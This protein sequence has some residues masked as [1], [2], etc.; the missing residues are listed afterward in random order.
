MEFKELNFDKAFKTICNGKSIKQKGDAGGIPITRIETIAN[1]TIDESKFGYADI[2]DITKY[3]NHI[4][5]EGDILLSHINSL[6][7]IGKTALFNKLDYPV[8]HGM[9]L[10]RLQVADGILDPRYAFYYLQTDS[11]KNEILKFVKKSVNQVSVPV[12]S[13]KR[14]KI[15]FPKSLDNQKRIVQVLSNCE[16][17]IQKRK[18][19]ISLLDELLK[20]TF[21]EM[22]GDP[23]RNEKKWDYKSIKEHIGKV[24]TGNTPPRKDID[25]YGDFIEW[26]K[27][28]NIKRKNK[29]LSTSREYLSKK[30]KELGRIVQKDSLLI[31]CIAGSIK[32]I[33]NIAIVNREVAFNQQINAITPNDDV[34]IEFLYWMFFISKEYLESKANKGMKKMISKSDFEKINFPKPDYNLQLK[35]SVISKKVESI[36]LNYQTHLL[37]LENL[38]GSMSQKAFKGELDLSKVEIINIVNASTHITGKSSGSSNLTAKLTFTNEK[39]APKLS[40]KDKGKILKSIILNEFR[41]TEF[42]VPDI[43]KYLKERRLDIDSEFIKSYIKNDLLNYYIKQAYSGTTQQI[44][45][46][47]LK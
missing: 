43:E 40:K 39:V 26:I 5:N 47:L 21:L 25:N 16:N 14:I 19:S 1:R 34:D 36:K 35:F 8:I 44:M 11:Y 32:S 29:F 23:V 33:G 4:L 45:F 31:S 13:I 3:S 27:T 20:S 15:V 41:N 6:K 42:T 30:G 24:S 46:K 9:N 38:Y 37:E 17:L 7:H 2:T 10:L 18:L 28:D 12:S 22:F